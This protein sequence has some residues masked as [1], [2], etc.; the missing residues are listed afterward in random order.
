MATVA[1]YRHNPLAPQPTLV[2]QNVHDEYRIF[3]HPIP[4]YGQHI[5][6]RGDS[7]RVDGRSPTMFRVGYL[8]FY[9]DKTFAL[10]QELDGRIMGHLSAE[11]WNDKD[12]DEWSWCFCD[13]KGRPMSYEEVAPHETL[14]LVLPPS[15]PNIKSLGGALKKLENLLES[16]EPGL[17]TWRRALNDMSYDLLEALQKLYERK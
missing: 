13:E 8:D 16:P 6:L 4:R 9:E 14:S 10:I 1:W 2:D 3:A 5:L 15:L 17:F 11:S 7:D 12:V